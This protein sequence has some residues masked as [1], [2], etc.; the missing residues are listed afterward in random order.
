MAEEQLISV[1]VV[2]EAIKLI[3]SGG[4]GGTIVG[5]IG[6]LVVDRKLQNQKAVYDKQLESLKSKL[7]LE[8]QKKVIEYTSLH[9]KQA[10]IIADFYKR[11]SYLYESIQRL[12]LKYQIREWKKEIEKDEEPPIVPSYAQLSLT[13]EEKQV[14]SEVETYNKELWDF[15]R[16]NK[17]Y[18]SLKICQLT[19]RFC[20][21]T[22]NLAGSY[23]DVTYKNDKG[24]L[25]VSKNVK[26]CWDKTVEIIPK[27]LI[28]LEKE[29]RVILGVKS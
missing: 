20:G 4:L 8:T 1:E 19:D 25:Y 22:W 21:L 3:V 15:Y 7:L 14:I 2:V 24:Q 11:L 6:K 12:L 10:Q 5:I 16:I 28:Q 26:E 13:A 29:F 18:L 23:F 9:D 27:L 17:I